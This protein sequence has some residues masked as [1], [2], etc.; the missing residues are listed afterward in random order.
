MSSILVQQPDLGVSF[1]APQNMRDPREAGDRAQNLIYEYGLIKTP[2]GFAKLDLSSGLNSGDTV[3]AILP[4]KETDGYDHL[5]AVTTDK[6]YEHDRVNNDWD[7]RSKGGGTYNS[8]ITN[9]ISYAIVGHNDTNIYLDENTS[10]AK[11]YYHLIICDG[12]LSDIQRWAGRLE[13][14][15]ENVG[16]GGGYH[17]GTTHRAHQVETFKSRLVLL[18]PRTYSASSA[19]WTESNQ[20]IRWPQVS[21]LQSWSGTGSGFVDL[22]DTGGT[23]VWSAHLG[24]GQFIVYQTQGVWSLNYVG[25][26]D[27]FQPQVMI[28]DLGLL[29]PHLLVNYRNVHY[30]VTTDYQVVAYYGGTVKQVIGEKIHKDLQETLDPQYEHRCW[31]VMGP[32]SKRLWIYTVP[33]GDTNVTK[34]Y[35][36]DMRTGNWQV[37]DF[38]HRWASGGITAVSLVGAQS[39]T[40]GESY[41]EAGA[42]TYATAVTAGETYDDVVE[43]VLTQPRTVIGDDGG[44][45]YQFDSTYTTDDGEL[46]V[47]RHPTPV[48]DGGQPDLFK[49]WP[50]IAVVADGTVDGAMITRY[51]TGNFDTSDTGWADYT[52]DLTAEFQEETFWT[53]TTSKSIQF[54]LRDFSGKAFSVRE[55]KVLEPLLESDR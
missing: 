35:G 38:K 8:N 5:I 41:D 27:I 23:N 12:G 4:F 53:N 2:E 40:E 37:R 14:D 1:L 22:V 43:T 3:L 31:M 47:Q 28:P 13:A 45:V 9:P 17:D 20:R 49:R 55:Y 16:G 19:A 11:A 32:E 39:Y 7:D 29:A 36:M 46:I 50:G 52:F 26:T 21:K 25:G 15:F 54:E 30:L 24:S 33:N 42:E 48:F 44:F 51:R 18:S 10:K 6:I 34:A